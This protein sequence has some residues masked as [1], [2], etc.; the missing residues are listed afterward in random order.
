MSHPLTPS[1][2]IQPFGTHTVSTILS[3][4]EP[5]SH[6]HTASHIVEKAE[7]GRVHS[8]NIN[9]SLAFFSICFSVSEQSKINNQKPQTK[10]VSRKEK[11]IPT[12]SSSSFRRRGRNTMTLEGQICTQRH[13]RS[14]GMQVLKEN[15]I[16][17]ILD[18]RV[19]YMEKERRVFHV[20]RVVCE[21]RQSHGEAW[22][23]YFKRVRFSKGKCM[24]EDRRGQGQRSGHHQNTWK[25]ML[26]S[27]HYCLGARKTF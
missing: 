11:K 9:A 10:Q 4:S 2:H 26:S 12:L 22:H 1:L 14:K 15:T 3:Q 13:H 7:V 24:I 20:S 27:L 18:C 25:A 5:L 6:K 19:S 23:M 16:S 21:K 17:Q 8:I